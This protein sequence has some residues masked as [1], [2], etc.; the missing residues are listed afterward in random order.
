MQRAVGD[1]HDLGDDAGARED[2][3]QLE[4]EGAA[5]RGAERDERRRLE[6]VLSPEGREDLHDARAVLLEIPAP[7]VQPIGRGDRNDGKASQQRG[8]DEAH[9]FGKPDALRALCIVRPEV[10]RPVVAAMRQE[11]QGGRR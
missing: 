10:D 11:Q 4:H 2:L 5:R 8:L 1:R 7:P 9:L 6:R 3:R